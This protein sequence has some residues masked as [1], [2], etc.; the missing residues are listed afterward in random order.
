MNILIVY[1][2]DVER[3]DSGGSRTTVQLVDYLSKKSD[4]TV[5]S[6]F[7]IKGEK[8]IKY[9]Y[10]RGISSSETKLRDFLLRHNIDI[11]IIPEGRLYTNMA[12]KAIGRNSQIK[13]ISA[14]HNMPGYERIGLFTLLKESYK[15]NENRFKRIRA[16][17]LM[18]C[19]PL[20]YFWF[21]TKNVLAYHQAYRNADKLVLLSQKFVAEYQRKYWVE[22]YDKFEAIGNALSFDE[23]A[24]SLDLQH[25]KKQLLFV[26]RLAEQSKR[27][28][29]ILKIW[30][31]IYKH[32]P[33]WHL[34]IVGFGRSEKDYKGYVEKKHLPRVNFEGKQKPLRYYRDSSIFLMT[35]AFEGWGMTLTEAQQ[36]GCV[37]VAMKS[38]SS[39][40]DIIHDGVDGYVVNNNDI[41][42]FCLKVSK[43]M[44]NPDILSRMAH[45]AIK[46]SAKFEKQIVCEK[47]Y[48]LC[49]T[50]ASPI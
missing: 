46:S 5:F 15:Y 16:L 6:N 42:S 24:T 19:Y 49:K 8:D 27:V 4:C 48:Q 50:L 22:G 43:L 2:R 35:S 36:M 3:E 38:F 21:V 10:E 14:L 23:Y 20:F 40:V 39:V 28:S 12:R 37:P 44:D 18:A 25:K 7:Q 31:R 17:F 30:E 41:D 34:I 47:Y 13:I 1:S 26:G 32:H 29:F 9:I 11:I 45:N 33:D